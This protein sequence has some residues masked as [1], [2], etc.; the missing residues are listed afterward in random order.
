MSKLA[1]AGDSSTASPARASANARAT[2]AS[3][4]PHRLDRRPSRPRAP[5]A[6]AARRGRS[7]RTARQRRGRR[8]S[9]SGA[10]ILPL[11]SPPAISTTGA[12]MPVAARPTVAPT[13][14]PSNRR[15]TGRRALADALHPV[16]QAAETRAAPSSI[17]WR[18]RATDEPSAS[19]ASAF[20][21]L[22]G[23]RAGATRRARAA[24][25]RARATRRPALRRAP[26]R[27][28]DSGTDAPKVCSVSPCARIRRT[29]GSSRFSTCTAAPLKMRA[30]AAA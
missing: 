1:H 17:G 5:R 22:C 11:P 12:P 7:A 3:S 16:R 8:P 2:A 26:T 28:S 29:I 15:R 30:F 9:R 4:V 10:K 24:R 13:L 18:M 27:S 23:R 19:A 14:V 6:I 20:S 21:A 25:R